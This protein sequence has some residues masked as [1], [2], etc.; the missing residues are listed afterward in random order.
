MIANPNDLRHLSKTPLPNPSLWKPRSRSRKSWAT[1]PVSPRLR[2][3]LP[4]LQWHEAIFPKLTSRGCQDWFEVTIQEAALDIVARLSSRVFLG[5]DVC[6]DEKWL[7]ITKNYTM[8]QNQGVYTMRLFPK[9]FRPVVYLFDPSCRK[10]RQLYYQ[11]RDI[12]EPVVAKRRK[13]RQQPDG[14]PVPVHNDAIEW[15]ESEAAGMA[16]DPTDFQLI[17]SFAAIHTTTDLICQTMVQLTAD[18]KNVEALRKEMLEVLPTGGWKKASIARL[19]LLDS[20]IKEAQRLKPIMMRKFYTLQLKVM[21]RF[22][23]SAGCRGRR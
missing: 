7:E 10:T 15:A 14:A 4:H 19:K 20:A 13:E 6:R 9:F 2:V 18:P 1:S 22:V 16:Y 17:L 11:A 5:S 23:L 21:C 3:L 8:V 12:V